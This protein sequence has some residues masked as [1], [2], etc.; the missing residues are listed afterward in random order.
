MIRYGRCLA[1]FAL[2]ILGTVGAHASEPRACVPNNLVLSYL[3]SDPAWSIVDLSDLSSDDQ[4]L[5]A[6]HH[7]D[8]CP[9]LA[10]GRLD[11]GA[12]TWYALALLNKNHG[13]LYEK[14][15]LLVEH[16]LG[17]KIQILSASRNITSPFVIWRTGPGVFLDY[18]TGKM[19]TI[20]HDSFVY[21]KMESTA[22][23]Y[24]LRD[25]RVR[26]LIATY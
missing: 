9:G 15:V 17:T 11:S 14:V 7:H 25:G 12:H 10:V 26:E 18:R 8:L 19:I 23:Q 24:Y 5:W 2:F 3:K 1:L 16:K 22:V 21:E 4:Q 6:Q 20:K 13:K